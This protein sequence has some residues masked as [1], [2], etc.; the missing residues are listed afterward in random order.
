CRVRPLVSLQ[1]KMAED[2]PQAHPQQLVDALAGLLRPLK[3][4]HGL[5]FK[6]QSTSVERVDFH[7][8]QELCFIRIQEAPVPPPEPPI[9]TSV[10]IGGGFYI[11]EI[12]ESAVEAAKAAAER[13]KRSNSKSLERRPS[14]SLERST[15]LDGTGSQAP[16][17]SGT[18]SLEDGNLSLSRSLTPSV[19]EEDGKLSRRPSKMGS[20]LA[21]PGGPVLLGNSPSEKKPGEETDGTSGAEETESN[22]GG[23]TLNLE[24]LE[25]AGEAGEEAN[26]RVPSKFIHGEV[27]ESAE[28]DR[29]G[30]GFHFGTFTRGSSRARFGDRRGLKPGEHVEDYMGAAPNADCAFRV[31]TS[32]RRRRNSLP[33]PNL[34][35]GSKDLSAAVEE[36]CYPGS[37]AMQ[38]L[39]EALG[40]E[41]VELDRLQV[42]RSECTVA[43]KWKVELCYM[44][45]DSPTER[46]VEKEVE[47]FVEKQVHVPVEVPKKR[48]LCDDTGCQTTG[49]WC[50]Y[51]GAPG[52]TKANCPL[53][54]LQKRIKELEDQLKGPRH[55]DCQ[56]C[57]SCRHV[58]PDCPSL[59]KPPGAN[60]GVQTDPSCQLCAKFGHFAPQCPL[61]AEL[62]QPKVEASPARIRVG[63]GWLIAPQVPGL[64]EGGLNETDALELLASAHTAGCLNKE[65]GQVEYCGSPSRPGSAPSSRPVSPRPPSS[66]MM[67]PR[68]GRAQATSSSPS[69]PTSP[70]SPGT[71]IAETYAP[72]DP[73]RV[74]SGGQ[75]GPER[76]KQMEQ[77]RRELS[78]RIS[79]GQGKAPSQGPRGFIIG[80][81]VQGSHDKHRLSSDTGP[82]TMYRVYRSGISTESAMDPESLKKA[83]SRSRRSSLASNPEVSSDPEDDCGCGH[84]ESHE[85]PQI[86]IVPAGSA[87]EAVRDNHSRRGSKSS[88]A[89][90]SCSRE[91]PGR[92]CSKSSTRSSPS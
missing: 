31:L 67:S 15:T 4:C 48:P 16:S 74:L 91:P 57:G 76:F 14:K 69:R 2:A 47:V 13:V 37:E 75:M 45:A 68:R 86:V 78:E 19:L 90:R 56:L 5:R 66:P 1:A 81:F 63:G 70:A 46:T 20:S 72:K 51:C 55:E 49:I 80:T 26:K 3:L 89:S 36:S 10:R 79:N 58:A 82:R 60:V 12:R 77:E 62:L 28:G 34:R 35:R 50:S 64:K 84:C 33:N 22:V 39:I 61:L 21:L 6:E 23:S 30:H 24:Y 73:A 42:Q 40:H 17:R 65:T 11:P 38:A 29:R 9:P 52:H 7:H 92:S 59:L 83:Q 44:Y 27:Q 53:L 25:E 88:V 85:Q 32:A 87:T 71:P 41:V 43:N 8:R 54:A 18:M